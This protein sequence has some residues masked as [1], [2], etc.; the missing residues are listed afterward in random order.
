MSEPD[1]QDFRSR[2]IGIVR[3]QY[4]THVGTPIQPSVAMSCP[5]EIHIYSEFNAG[6]SDLEGFERLWILAWLDR[7]KPY[8]LRVVPYKDTVERG[9][10]ATRAPSRPSP[11]GI[12]CVKIV[13][14]RLAEGIIDIE[15]IDLLD[16]TPVLDIKPY[17]P[18]FDAFPAAKHGWYAQS[19]QRTTADDRFA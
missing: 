6:L 9:L 10:F 19:E 11:I 18:E 5:A 14:V 8:C 15:S 12:S 2:I 4:L 17:I 13:R 1:P 16:G 3:S 7:A